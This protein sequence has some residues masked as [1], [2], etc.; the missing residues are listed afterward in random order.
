[1]E[2]S[3]TELSHEL[4]HD[5]RPEHRTHSVENIEGS[6][7]THGAADQQSEAPVFV[8]RDPAK[9]EL[10]CDRSGRHD[11][12]KEAYRSVTQ[13]PALN[14]QEDDPAEGQD[15]TVVCRAEPE[16]KRK[17]LARMALIVVM[18]LPFSVCSIISCYHTRS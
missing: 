9:G 18:D 1:M 10:Q 17:T 3:G 13:T 8:V 5:K 4:G 14:G 11:K 16:T 12:E 6:D 15:T 2:A 7:S